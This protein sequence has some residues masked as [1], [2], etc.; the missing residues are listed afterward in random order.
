MLKG[1][2][3]DYDRVNMIVGRSQG[4]LKENIYT[5]KMKILEATTGKPRGRYKDRARQD[6][7]SKIVTSV[8]DVVVYEKRRYVR[9]TNGMLIPEKWIGIYEWFVG[10]RAPTMW[11]ERMKKSAPESMSEI[12]LAVE[13]YSAW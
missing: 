3:N 1:M 7:R 11:I 12:D 6:E 5:P 8:L 10:R 9:I 13:E 2:R 4:N